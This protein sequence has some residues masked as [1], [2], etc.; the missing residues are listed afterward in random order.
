MADGGNNYLFSYFKGG[1][2]DG[3]HMAF[4]HDGL[5]WTAL[6]GDRSLLT[7]LIGQEKLMRDPCI[8]LGGDGVF[9]MSWTVGWWEKSI[10]VA[11]SK[12]LIEWSEQQLVPVMEHEPGARNS[13]APEILYDDAAEQYM[14]YWA[15]TIAG[16]FPETEGTGDDGLNH[17]IYY[18][19]TRDFRSYSETRLLYDGGFEAI[20]ATI[21]KHGDKHVMVLKDET[22]HPVRKHLRLTTA[23]RA[24]GPYGPASPPISPDWVEGPSALKIGECWVVYYDEFKRGCYGAIR[25]QDLQ[26]WEVISDRVS[27]PDGARHGTAL[28]V[29]GDVLAR[30][31]AA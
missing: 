19:T 16:R 4:S 20:D 21:F 15:T 2:E 30:L 14:I 27:F 6:K 5:C 10:G 18:V 12:D 31:L 11:H 1:G 29:S 13:W 17:R 8:V 24:E 7:P 23:D 9:H 26:A 28:A 22:L 3:L 25:S